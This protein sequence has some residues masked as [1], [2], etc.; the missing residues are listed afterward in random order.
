MLYINPIN[1]DLFKMKESESED[2]AKKEN[3]SYKDLFETKLN[4]FQM[5]IEETLSPQRTV[6]IHA[7]SPK[8]LASSQENSLGSI[9]DRRIRNYES[10]EG[11]Y[12]DFL[13]KHLEAYKNKLNEESFIRPFVN[14]FIHD[15]KNKSLRQILQK[16]FTPGI[17]NE[18]MPA[19]IKKLK[20]I[21]NYEN[22]FFQQLLKIE[23]QHIITEILE[24]QFEEKAIN[25]DQLL[26]LLVS[27]LKNGNTLN[28]YILDITDMV[29]LI[30]YI[31]SLLQEGV[32]QR[33]QVLVRNGVHYT[34]VDLELRNQNLKACV[35]ESAGKT[36]EKSVQAII[37]VLNSEK[38]Q[39]FLVGAD[40][41]IQFDNCNCA[42]F[43]LDSAMQSSKNHE[44]FDD[45]TKLVKYSENGIAHLLWSDLP[46]N[47]VE[48][49]SSITFLEKYYE[50][51]SDSRSVEY[52]ANLTFEK[53]IESHKNSIQ[54]KGQMRLSNVILKKKVETYKAIV[55]KAM[56]VFDQRVL[57]EVVH[58]YP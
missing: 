25:R 30:E 18:N 50:K 9:F 11:E 37:E 44:L 40:D 31:H 12:K 41:A 15:I 53:Y 49:A 24:T 23:D 1:I 45:L 58:A 48:N 43:A 6:H 35:M 4:T 54:I 7:V 34:A 16:Y 21:F 20:D 26:R 28:C 17:Q 29:P 36:E 19:P 46:P 22:L 27:I 8:K 52:K 13:I 51:H 42:Y 56:R 47:F 3:L 10:E 57:S 39:I 2:G 5:Q 55:E 14:E 33:M 38:A 32:E